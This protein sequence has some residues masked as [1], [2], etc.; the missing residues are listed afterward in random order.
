MR[1]GPADALPP[2]RRRRGRRRDHRR[3]RRVPPRPRRVTDVVVAERDTLAAAA[4]G[5]PIGGLR[6][7]FSDRLNALL[8]LRSLEAYAELGA[9]M[10]HQRVGYLFLLRGRSTSRASRPASRCRTTSASRASCST[11]PKPAPAALRSTLR[12]SSPPRSAPSTGTRAPGRRLGYADGARRRGARFVPG[13]AVTGI[14][15]RDGEIAAVRT[16]QGSCAPRRSSAR[17]V[18]GRAR[19]GRWRVSSSTSR[20][21]DGRSPSPA[22]RR[23]RRPGCRSRS[24]SAP[25]S[26]STAP[27]TGCCSGCRTPPRRRGRRGLR[28]RWE[29]ALREAAR[30]AP[31]SRTCRSPRAGPGSTR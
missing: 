11:P 7:Q 4:S 25:P 2:R 12:R 15:V 14:D 24:T 30:C 5:K 6:A 8:A 23:S 1:D 18:R 20:R 21:C 16:T 27:A 31:A 28:A 9:D 19:S 22:R 17:R 3:R 29:P 10:D 26:T 13:C